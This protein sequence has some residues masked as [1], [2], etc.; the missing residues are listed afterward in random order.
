MHGCLPEKAAG[1]AL[2]L[3]VLCAGP[4]HSATTRRARRWSLTLPRTDAGQRWLQ[5]HSIFCAR[6]VPAPRL[7][8][9]PLVG[10]LPV[11]GDPA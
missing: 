6:T 1:R 10:N 4:S 7:P 8:Y 5:V 9:R 3:A 11:A 2:A